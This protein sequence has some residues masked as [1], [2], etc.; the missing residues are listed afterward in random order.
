MKSPFDIVILGLGPQGLFLLREFSRAGQNVLGLGLK[1][2]VGLHS[3]YGYKL[4]LPQ[5]EALDKILP[6]F[7]H[8]KI[9][10]HMTSD[11]FLNYMLKK[12]KKIFFEYECFPNYDSAV[13]FTVKT[14]TEK[15]AR[16]LEIPCQ[17]SVLL[18]NV[19]FSSYDIFPSI[20]KWNKRIG[21]EKFK[22]V[23]VYSREDLEI[24][25]KEIRSTENLIVQK[26]IPGRRDADMSFGGYFKN[27]CEQA[28][29]IIQQ[30]RQYP[31]PIGLA[32]Y[33]EEYRG[34]FVDE[35]ILFSHRIL[36][37]TNYSGFV[38]VE[39][40]VGQDDE[41]LYLIE[42]NPRAC[43][44]IKI[45]KAK[46]KN[47]GKVQI[48]NAARNSNRKASWV[49]LQRDIRA[50][51]DCLIK[52]RNEFCITEL[53]RSYLKNPIKDIFDIRDIKPFLCQFLRLLGDMRH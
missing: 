14:E 29:I 37:S 24:F 3:K 6:D 31:H 38:E 28:S 27:G 52:N 46:M 39:F 23:V 36:R 49:N 13:V 21:P 26:F 50:N 43:G 20:I 11:L 34:D 17:R 1:G 22:T 30:K 53:V 2:T 51:V 25:R 16:K 48:P 15:L 42:V 33:V 32:S 19:D 12:H 7:L 9:S 35:I 10:L 4:A 44:W 5:I 8:P 45:I 40:R 18:E 47:R 41:K